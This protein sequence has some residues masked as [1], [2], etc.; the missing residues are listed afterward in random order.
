MHR[1]INLLIKSD[2]N[3]SIFLYNFNKTFSN[4]NWLGL[5]QNI[6]SIIIV[7]IIIDIGETNTFTRWSIKSNEEWEKNELAHTSEAKQ[8]K[9]EENITD[10]WH[11]IRIP[12][13]GHGCGHDSYDFFSSFFFLLSTLSVCL[14][15]K[16]ILKCPARWILSFCF[17]FNAIDFL[18]PFFDIFTLWLCLWFTSIH[19]MP[20]HIDSVIC[21]ATATSSTKGKKWIWNEREKKTSALGLTEHT[22]SHDMIGMG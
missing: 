16:L 22:A 2:K 17:S 9:E 5:G 15:L 20:M 21:S 1:I 13:Y 18:L 10:T 3:P 8:K 19:C 14:E 7:I 11:D 6:I 12:I 4:F